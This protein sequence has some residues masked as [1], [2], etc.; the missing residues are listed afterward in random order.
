MKELAIRCSIY[1]PNEDGWNEDNPVYDADR[2]LE[3][4]QNLVDMHNGWH[5]DWQVYDADVRDV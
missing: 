3:D 4:I 5:F 1:I 2:A